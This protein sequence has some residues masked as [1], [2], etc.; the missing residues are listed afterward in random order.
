VCAQGN[1]Y[2]AEFL[3]SQGLFALWHSACDG[4]ITYPPTTSPIPALTTSFDGADC[5]SAESDCNV[6][7]SATSACSATYRDF[8]DVRSCFCQASVLGV[9]SMCDVEFGSCLGSPLNS[10]NLFSYQYC[11]GL[12]GLTPSTTEALTTNVRSLTST[13]IMITQSPSLPNTE[14]ASPGLSSSDIAT[15]SSGGTTISV[16]LVEIWT[17]IGFNV[18]YLF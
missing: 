13:R 18:W 8:S 6:L 11:R 15:R 4:T 3:G 10:T 2:D 5:L 7:S 1:A 9:A 16:I 14:T 17:I 12:V